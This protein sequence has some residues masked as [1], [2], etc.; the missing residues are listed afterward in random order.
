MMLRDGTVKV[1]DFGI[2]A[3]ENEIYENNGQ[4]VGSIH[5]IAPEQARG[6]CPDARS[7]VYSLG[8]VM[9]EMLTGHKPYEGDTIVDRRKTHE[10]RPRAAA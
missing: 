7:D 10:R 2:A 6:E 3:L 8:V 4:A 5:Y 9:Y 1:A